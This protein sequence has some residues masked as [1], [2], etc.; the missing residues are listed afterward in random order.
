MNKENRNLYLLHILNKFAEVLIFS[1]LSKNV[2]ADCNVSSINKVA[3][4]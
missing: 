3:I 2:I 1:G 4:L